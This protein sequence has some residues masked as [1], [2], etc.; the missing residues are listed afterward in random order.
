MRRTGTGRRGHCKAPC[1]RLSWGNGANPQRPR[2]H[3][4]RFCRITR[5]RVIGLQPNP[6]KT[7][8]PAFCVAGA[9][10]QSRIGQPSLEHL[11]YRGFPQN[12]EFSP[13]SVAADD[14]Y[15]PLES[16]FAL[17][18]QNS[19]QRGPFA[20]RSFSGA[21]ISTRLLINPLM[22]RK[23]MTLLGHSLQG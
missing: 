15:A 16:R 18:A 23:L 14:T 3:V 17:L 10:S 22:Q 9:L 19:R 1:A 4:G 8:S 11:P 6:A 12:G 5:V 2:R 21:Q 13:H 7:G 20:D